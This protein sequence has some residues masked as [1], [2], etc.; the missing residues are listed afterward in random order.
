MNQ[1]PETTKTK[2]HYW[3]REDFDVLMDL[4]PAEDREILKELMPEG[5]EFP[6]AR[7]SSTSL[8]YPKTTEGAFRE[9]RLRGLQCSASTLLELVEQHAVSPGGEWSSLEWSKDDIDQAA[10]W[11]YDNQ[12]WTSWTHFCWVTNVRFGQA[13]KSRRVASARFGLPFDMSFDP[14]GLVT[15]IE[16]PTDPDD[17]AYVRFFPRGTKIEPAEA[18]K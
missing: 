5:I 3:L 8:T 4:M 2:R 10:E 15:V 14:L 18:G 9:L 16:P 12:R 1:M 17:Y 11:L 13:V 6:R 7:S